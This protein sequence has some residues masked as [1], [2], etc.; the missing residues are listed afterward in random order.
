MWEII[1]SFP[2]MVA[3]TFFQIS[4]FGKIHL[5]QGN[6]DLLMLIV[7][8]WA[9]NDATHYSW[10]W[11][12]VGG[13]IMSYVSALSL[14]GYLIL[15]ALLWLLIRLIKKRVWQMPVVLMLFLTIIG[16]GL[17]C[18][19]TLGTLVLQNANIDWSVALEQIVIP[20][21]TMNLF[22]AVPVYAIMN[23][24]ANTIYMNEES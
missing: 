5:I 6:T 14:H 22:L 10:L 18:A 3:V 24:I 9:L 20:S 12:L 15:Y 11:A 13:L 4:V 21:L 16:T 19:F 23:D 2:L 1:L 17:E 7:I 8:A